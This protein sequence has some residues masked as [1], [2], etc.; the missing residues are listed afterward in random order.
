MQLDSSG[1]IYPS[2]HNVWYILIRS[3]SFLSALPGSTD[4]IPD[5]I[6]VQSLRLIGLYLLEYIT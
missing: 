2:K 6:D 1:I 5:A 4:K 3:Q